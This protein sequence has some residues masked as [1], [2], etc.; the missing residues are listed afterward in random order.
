[1]SETKRVNHRGVERRRALVDAAVDLWSSTGYRGTGITAVAERA[2]VTPAGLLHHFGTKDH[3]LLAVV[4]ELDRRTLASF[5]DDA[6]VRGAE[7]FDLLPELARYPQDQPAL[8]RLILMLQ[9]ENFDVESP[10]HDYFV[11]RQ[12]VIHEMIAG[13]LRRGQAD[14]ELRS[15]IDPGLVAAQCLAF[16]LGLQM[17]REHGPHNV[18]LVAVA[19]DFADRLRRDLTVER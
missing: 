4:E 16:L 5:P 10:A 15:D 14:G 18:D 8:W 13:A 9:A 17:Y 2:G 11:L 7:L 19:T 12:A 6:D 3:F 1:M